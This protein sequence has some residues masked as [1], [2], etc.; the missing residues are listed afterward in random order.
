MA[1]AG[2]SSAPYVAGHEFGNTSSG[3]SVSVNKPSGAQVGD[4]LIAV[5]QSFLSVSWSF[6]SSGFTKVASLAQIPSTAIAYK[7]VTASEPASYFFGS[8]SNTQQNVFVILIKNGSYDTVGSF[9]T[10]S[11]PIYAP[12]IVV[13]KNNSLLLACYARGGQNG[14][15]TVPSGME[16]VCKDSD[17]NPPSSAVF[18]QVVNA[19]SSGSRSSNI[20]SNVY[21]SGILLAISPN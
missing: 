20:G 9:S 1:A 21:V 10:N 3:S 16:P 17:A 4:I 13:S 12:S 15:A 14:D 7:Y 19:G 2:A 8:S 11:T 6:T 5:C 18:S